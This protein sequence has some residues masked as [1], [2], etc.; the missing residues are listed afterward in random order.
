MGEAETIDYKNL[1]QRREL[2]KKRQQQRKKRQKTALL[3]VCIL[4]GLIIGVTGAI[5]GLTAGSKEAPNVSQI[6]GIPL[7][8]DI[9]PKGIPGR[10]G[11]TRKIKYLV[12]HETG[13]TGRNANAKSHDE[14]IHS[15]AQKKRLSWHYTV[16]DHSIYQHLPDNEIGYHAGDGDGHIKD[17]GNSSGIGIE[18][19]V[20]PENDYEQTLKNTA[21]LAAHLLRAYHLD[22]GAVKKHQDFSGKL[23]PQRLIES[24]RWDEFLDMVQSAYQK[25]V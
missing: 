13:N 11:E 1:E 17:T 10:P 4:L 15:V 7:I 3:A 5:K 16:D 14:Y 12:I 21:A 9:L 18:M 20:N 24:G 23:C 19:C 6:N 8:R 22:L 25:G 2:R